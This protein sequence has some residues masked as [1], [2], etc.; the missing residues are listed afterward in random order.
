[1]ADIISLQTSPSPSNPTRPLPE[2]NF[3]PD[4]YRLPEGEVKGSMSPISPQV[5]FI[6]VTN[7]C[8]L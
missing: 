5:V 2:Q 6:E 1:M 3:L 4:A 7:R 8:N